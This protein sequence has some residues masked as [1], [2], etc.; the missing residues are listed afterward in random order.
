MILI[1][2]GADGTGKSTLS[3]ELS[4]YGFQVMHRPFDPT[5]LDFF[6]AY[7][8]LLLSL[9]E[10]IILDRSFISEIVYGPILRG[11]SRLSPQE[12]IEL[13]RITANRRGR[14]LYCYA[15]EHVIR[16][17]LESDAV[18]HGKLIPKL[19]KLLQAYEDVIDQVSRHVSVFRIK[20]DEAAPAE[21]ASDVMKRAVQ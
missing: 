11:Q 19:P 21:I 2:E 7:R 17:R 18:V 12:L 14:V 20:T 1:L 4:R 9:T 16:N 5:Y 10:D 6:D 15:A 8:K 13:L 3:K